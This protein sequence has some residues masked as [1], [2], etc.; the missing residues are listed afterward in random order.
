MLTLEQMF[1]MQKDL[2]AKIVREKGLEGKDLIPNT[3][4]A[5]QVELGELANEW[6]G[7]KHWSGRQEPKHGYDALI[8]CDACDGKG[9][10]LSGARVRCSECN[11]TGKVLNP[12]LEE[13]VDCLHFFL[14]L[15]RQIGLTAEDMTAWDMEAEGEATVLFTEILW[16]ISFV[17]IVH[18]MEKKP[19]DIDSF[20]KE[21]F[22]HAL[23]LFYAIGDQ[24]FDFTFEQIAEAY[25]KKNAVNHDRQA[26]GY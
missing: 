12:L 8:D 24:R 1:E 25:A 4:L 20:R 23:F 2:D 18:L 11:E 6:R 7:F 22:R 19:K 3:V 9:F 14:S 13:Y 21:Q 16:H 17:Q 26:N 15:G 10:W 5:L